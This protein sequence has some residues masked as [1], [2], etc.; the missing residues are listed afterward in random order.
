MIFYVLLTYG[1]KPA[2]SIATHPAAQ[3][4]MRFYRNLVSHHG[5]QK[6]QFLYDY[7]RKFR[8]LESLPGLRKLLEALKNKEGGKVYIDDVARLLKGCE[9]QWRVGFL[10][11]LREHGAQI[12]S[13]KHRKSLDEFSGAMLKNLVQFAEKSKHPAQQ[14][15]PKDTQA[16]RRSSS[17]VR[18]SNAVR[19]AR[20]LAD[21]R[22][23][24]IARSGY[25]SGLTALPA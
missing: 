21:L 1:K 25:P 16:A 12:Y 14:A 4:Q 22:Q 9:L 7:S 18:S 8:D 5:I 17:E 13:L 19:H 3:S 24:L 23:E 11:E 15:R 2:G 20:P 6:T 10:E